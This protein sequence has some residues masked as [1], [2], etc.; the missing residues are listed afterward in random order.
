MDK[1]GD[2]AE[3]RTTLPEASLGLGRAELESAVLSQQILVLY[4]S[5]WISVF[6]IANAGLTAFVLRDLLPARMFIGW[7]ALFLRRYSGAVT[8][9]H[10]LSSQ[11]AANGD[12]RHLGLA[13]CRRHDCHG[14]PL[15]TNRSGHPDYP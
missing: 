4:E 11:A 8:Q 10:A 1:S 12:G 13:L 2:A 15:G 14:L 5:H 6:N 9:P 7:I 3:N